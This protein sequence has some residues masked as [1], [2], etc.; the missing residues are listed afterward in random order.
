MMIMKKKLKVLILV[1][2]FPTLTETFIVNQIID[3]INRGHSVYIFATGKTNQVVHS[4]I[5]EYNLL[6][7]VI[8]LDPPSSVW[9]RIYYF[10]KIL[11]S[12]KFKTS[13]KLMSSLNVF[14]FGISTL[15]LSNFYKIAWLSKTDDNYDIVHAH[16]GQMSEYY[17]LAQK[18]GFLKNAQL[19]TTF[20][21]YDITPSE[22]SL[23]KR[24][25][26][27]L[28]NQRKLVT[29]NTEYTKSLLMDIGFKSDNIRV[30]PVGLDTSFYKL[31]QERIDNKTID[32]LFIGRITKFKGVSRIPEICNILIREKEIKNIVFKIIGNIYYE[33]E[34]EL[35]KLKRKIEE[36]DLNQYF[37]LIGP[38]TQKEIIEEMSKSHMYIMPGICDSNGRAENQGLV[39]Q[40]AQA[41]QLPVVVTN[42][43]GMKYGLIQNKTGFVVDQNNINDFAD[44]L[45]FLINNPKERKQMGENARNFVEKN[46]DSKVLGD[47]LESIYFDILK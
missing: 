3:L 18:C 39:I 14:K 21:G 22:A 15:K 37:Q 47:Q 17:F 44:K 32:I 9:T 25:Y 38:M 7:K 45:E 27:S 42:A 26:H 10:L 31:E 20:H 4:K 12:T 2:T 19:I 8:Y 5:R 36:N 41:M 6:D 43:G 40:E 24:K 33:A 23:N 16:F 30:L 29:A 35:K 28:I 11:L 34:E 46:Y 1:P 13:L